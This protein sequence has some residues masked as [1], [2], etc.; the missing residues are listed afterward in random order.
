MK[1]K[2]PFKNHISHG[3]FAYLAI[4]IL[5]PLLCSYSIHLK[6]RPKDY[7]RFTFFSEALF[8]NDG[9]FKDLMFEVI[10]EDLLIDLYEMERSDRL[11]NTYLS[12][13][14][15]SSD[16]CLLSETTLS[17]FKTIPF[18]DLSGTS[19]EK[20]NNYVIDGH[21]IGVLYHTKE[22]EKPDDLFTFAEDNYY[23]CIIKDSVHL[24]GLGQEGK[25]NQVSRV[26]EYLVPHE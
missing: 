19:L 24:L 20:E 6:T 26:M 2:F 21:E 12:S 17:N 5:V 7:E 11:F 8:V 23:L 25:T 9:E 22:D 18:L 16:I 15:F 13:Y 1:I 14:G 3:F 10:P 4:I